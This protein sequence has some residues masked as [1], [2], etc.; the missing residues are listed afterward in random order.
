MMLPLLLIVA[1]R[2]LGAMA[3]LNLTGVGSLSTTLATHDPLFLL[4]YASWDTSA[5]AQLEAFAATAHVLPAISFGVIDVAVDKA[6]L[7]VTGYPTLVLYNGSAPPTE[8]FGDVSSIA[9]QHWLLHDAP[10]QLVRTQDEWTKLQRNPSTLLLAI[11]ACED[12]PPRVFIETLA[13]GVDGSFALTCNASLVAD[14]IPQPGSL[15][16]LWRLD[17]TAIVPATPFLGPWSIPDVLAFYSG[18][19][20]PWLLSY[21]PADALPVGALAYVLIFT[22]KDASWHSALMLQL[23]LVASRQQRICYLVVTDQSLALAGYFGVSARP[24]L[25]WYIDASTFRS[26]DRQGAALAAQLE[27]EPTA[28]RDRVL[29]FQQKNLPSALAHQ[30]AA[31]AP[32]AP[33]VRRRLVARREIDSAA[34]LSTMLSTLECVVVVFYSPRCPSCHRVLQWLDDV[35]RDTHDVAGPALATWNVDHMEAPNVRD[36]LG[37]KAHLPL[38]QRFCKDAPPVASAPMTSYDDFVHF[39]TSTV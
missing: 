3:F 1:L 11:T 26:L 37:D 12:D 23:H 20:S 18:A 25:V 33:V 38:V 34:M 31:V 21:N 7:H 24:G 2:A 32:P 16:A 27:Q 36:L 5:R 28:F 10:L 30:K 15:P 14:V 29:R 35:G 9:M 4:A 8:Y 39:I 22:D 13:N 6:A 17:A 19:T